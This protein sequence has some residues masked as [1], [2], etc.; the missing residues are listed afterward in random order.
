MTGP[1]GAC[2]PA[3]AHD[4]IDPGAVD[5]YYC[6]DEYVALCGLDLTDVSEGFEYPDVCP[7]C[8]LVLEVGAPCGVTGCQS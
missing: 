2:L 7:L 8:L 6:C 3:P 1:Q 5:H 4:R